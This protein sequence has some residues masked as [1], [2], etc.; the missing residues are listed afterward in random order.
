MQNKSHLVNVTKVQ[1]T[2][3]LQSGTEAMKGLIKQFQQLTKKEADQEPVV[4]EAP[5]EKDAVEGVAMHLLTVE[6]ML[7]SYVEYI[8]QQNDSRR[9]L[10]QR[11]Q[12]FIKTEIQLA[13][14][15]PEVSEGVKPLLAYPIAQNTAVK[16]MEH[17]IDV[18]E[19]YTSPLLEMALRMAY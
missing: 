10:I 16:L 13:S 1:G 18:T 4:V 11:T 3:A 12:A 14:Q 17:E 2:L 5:K 6:R 7:Q 15:M 9:N 8:A 19:S